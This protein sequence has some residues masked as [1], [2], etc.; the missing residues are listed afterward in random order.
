MN[1]NDT[2]GSSRGGQGPIGTNNT[3][4]Q[5]S[6]KQVHTLGN[7]IGKLIAKETSDAQVN[8]EKQFGN[9]G[10]QTWASL[11]ARNKLA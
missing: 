2:R 8:T 11:V 3:G 1:N 9:G 5:S 10:N 6:P 4:Y 7:T